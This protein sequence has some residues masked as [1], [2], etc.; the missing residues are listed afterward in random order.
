[1]SSDCAQGRV[2]NGGFN[3][4]A[5]PHGINAPFVI[6]FL[7]HHVSDDREVV[8]EIG[9][10]RQVLDGLPA[11][12]LHGMRHT[13]ASLLLEAGVSPKVVQERLGHSTITT[14][15]DTY[16]HVTPTM[17]RAAA[18]RFADAVGGGK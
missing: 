14:T 6:S 17:Q 13:H 12:T 10:A 5:S 16:A 7:A 18:D 11:L 15:M 3:P 9:K 4:K 2:L 1:M 8:G